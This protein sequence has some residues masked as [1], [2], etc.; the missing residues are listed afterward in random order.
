MSGRSPWPSY[1]IHGILLEQNQ[2]VNQNRDNYPLVGTKSRQNCH[3]ETKAKQLAR[4]WGPNRQKTTHKGLPLCR[5]NCCFLNPSQAYTGNPNN[6]LRGTT[7]LNWLCL[8]LRVSSFGPPNHQ[9][10]NFQEETV[11]MNQPGTK[12]GANLHEGWVIAN[13]ILVSF[14][15][16]FISSVLALPV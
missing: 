5:E 10:H 15:V 7:F 6:N 4:A 11:N 1:W 13:H 14:H 12:R 9:H 8:G 3:K 16:A 2:N